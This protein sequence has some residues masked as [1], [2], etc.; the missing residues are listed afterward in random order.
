MFTIGI[1]GGSGSGKTTFVNKIQDRVND[2]RLLV[3]HHDSYYLA[4]PSPA[5]MA[6]NRPNFDHPMAFD[7]A[8]F[9]KHLKEFSRGKPVPVPIYDYK[10]DR[11]T[12]EVTLLG[13]GKVMIVEGIFSLFDLEV[14][15]HYDLKIYLDVD[16]DIRF[17]RRLH[18]DTNERGRSL[19]SVISQYYDT[20]RPMYQQFLEPTSR[21][22]DLIVGEE[23]DIA[24]DAVAARI[25]QILGTF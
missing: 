24:A 22:A 3:L 11:R 9:K 7:W 13:P 17:I 15:K 4:E 1:A 19:D 12:D 14:R 6:D 20:V 25:K 21:F 18:R 8:L 23:T 10:K 16:S 5:L 2:A